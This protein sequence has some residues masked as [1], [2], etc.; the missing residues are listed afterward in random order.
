[1][2]A[3]AATTL[4]YWNPEITT[5]AISMVVTIIASAV[6]ASW[7]FTRLFSRSQVSF[8]KLELGFTTMQG[9][10]ST[11]KTSQ[12]LKFDAIHI[13]LKKQTEILTK[14]EVL[15]VQIAHMD[16]TQDRFQTHLDNLEDA[17][18]QFRVG[19]RISEQAQVGR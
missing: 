10:L 14:Q 3:E 9:D 1:M 2:I 17:L 11:Y 4:P 18:R 19:S 5:G 15:S 13:E 7:W 6:G 8:A 12:D 16:K